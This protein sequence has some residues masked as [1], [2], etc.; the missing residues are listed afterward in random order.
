[1]EGLR[2]LE[3]LFL[4]DMPT[5]LIAKLQRDGEDRQAVEHIPVIH[6]F[7]LSTGFQN[8]SQVIVSIQF[9]Y[10]VINDFSTTS[11]KL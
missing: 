7:N 1:M 6:S 10:L 3:E 9:L 8:L 2:K 11:L 4:H 5:I